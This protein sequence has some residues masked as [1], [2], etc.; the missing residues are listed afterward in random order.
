MSTIR[1]QI[2]TAAVAQ[3]NTGTPSGVPQADDHR[4]QSYTPEELPSIAVFEVREE[5]ETEKEGRWSY[6][7]KR[8][9]TLRVEVRFAGDAG[10]TVF[11]PMLV[12][13]GKQLGGFQFTGLAEDCY[14]SLTEWQY[15][16]LDQPYTLVQ[17][18]FRVHYSTLKGDPTRIS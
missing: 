12:W 10:R 1:S 16:D 2:V 3:L 6:F 5:S 18:D 14:E 9:F 13:I 11:D 17:I 7:L 4:Q 15:A 8:T